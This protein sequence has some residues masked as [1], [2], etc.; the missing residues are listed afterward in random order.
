VKSCFALV[1][2]SRQSLALAVSGRGQ[3]GVGLM[4]SGKATLKCSN[5]AKAAQK[6]KA[7]YCIGE[8][9]CGNFGRGSGLPVFGT[10][11]Q[12]YG[13]GGVAF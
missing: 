9:V 1:Q 3:P 7:R 2:Q 4:R 12:Y 5:V 11:E 13:T 8:G 6:R 10:P